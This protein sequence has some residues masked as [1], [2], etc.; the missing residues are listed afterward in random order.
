[1][2]ALFSLMFACGGPVSAPVSSAGADAESVAAAAGPA[3]LAPDTVRRV[4]GPNDAPMLEV[5]A[6]SPAGT[7]LGVLFA[8]E[9]GARPEAGGWLEQPAGTTNL[10]V[11]PEG[12]AYGAGRLRAAVRIPDLEGAAARIEVDAPVEDIAKGCESP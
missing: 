9:D 1:M 3:V 8:P 5:T 2:R 6:T 4:C 7:R 12:V 10:R 11:F